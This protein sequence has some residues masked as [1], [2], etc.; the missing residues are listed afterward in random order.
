MAGNWADSRAKPM[1]GRIDRMSGSFLRKITKFRHDYTHKHIKWNI[2][3][4]T[5]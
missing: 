3:K 2:L 5:L 1:T 4:P